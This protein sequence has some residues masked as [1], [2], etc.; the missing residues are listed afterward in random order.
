MVP[1]HLSWC[2]AIILRSR[3][4][5]LVSRPPG[6]PYCNS[7]HRILLMSIGLL[8]ETGG[9]KEEEEGNTYNR[10]CTDI[11]RCAAV[12]RSTAAALCSTRVR[13]RPLPLH[14]GRFCS[15]AAASTPLW[16]LSAVLRPLSA[17][18][19]PLY[20]E[21]RLCSEYVLQRSAPM[22]HHTPYT[23][24]GSSHSQ[25]R[26]P[27]PGWRRALRTDSPGHLQSEV[28]KVCS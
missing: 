8:S 22:G 15:T 3:G 26:R 5:Y 10:R 16:P 2:V 28:L 19:W 9:N 21:V 25:L 1:S 7:N 14:C 20:V 4:S 11:G 12:L 24:L 6:Q 18:L 23:I 17:L 27:G 13:F